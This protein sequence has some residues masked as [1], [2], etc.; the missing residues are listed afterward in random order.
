MICAAN[1][2]AEF[3]FRTAGFQPAVS[4]GPQNPKGAEGEASAPFV[5][6]ASS[7]QLGDHLRGL[8]EHGESDR[9]IEQ[10]RKRES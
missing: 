7:L 2:V 9:S 1:C 10:R 6:A 8:G 4:V 5:V 3:D